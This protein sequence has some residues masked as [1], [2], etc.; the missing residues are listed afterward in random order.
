MVAPPPADYIFGYVWKSPKFPRASYTLPQKHVSCR[1]EARKEVREEAR[2]RKKRET[3]K[4]TRK[5][6][7]R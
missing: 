7:T 6:T 4:E 3:Q 1:E 5:E 2:E